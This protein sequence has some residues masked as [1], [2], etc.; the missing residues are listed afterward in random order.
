MLVPVRGRRA[1]FVPRRSAAAAH[2]LRPTSRIRRRRRHCQRRISLVAVAFSVSCIC[3]QDWMRAGRDM[4]TRPC[5]HAAKMLTEGTTS[6]SSEEQ[7]RTDE[8]KMAT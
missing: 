5:K 2:V 8:S 1:F 3:V 4:T 6:G 7:T